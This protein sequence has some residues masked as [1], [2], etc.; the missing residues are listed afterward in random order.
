MELVPIENLGLATFKNVAGQK[1]T[2]RFENDEAIELL[3]TEVVSRGGAAFPDGKQ[4]EA[5]SLM[6]R[7]PQTPFLEQKM[8]SF[9]Q[10]EIGAFKL[11][12]VPIASDAKGFTYEAVF[13]RLVKKS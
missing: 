7:G 8:Y 9:E 11:F 10:P 6:F 13:N 1:F 5:F 2:V 12:I 3:L 4:S